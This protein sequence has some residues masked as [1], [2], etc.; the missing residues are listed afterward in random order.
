M[1]FVGSPDNLTKQ[2]LL[3]ILEK[4]LVNEQARLGLLLV[5]RL[6]RCPD[7]ARCCHHKRYRKHY[8][9]FARLCRPGN[10][11][12]SV[13]KDQKAELFVRGIAEFNERQFFACHETLETLWRALPKGDERDMIQSIIQIAVGFYH[14]ERA[15]RKGARKLLV[16]ATG[17]LA[18]IGR[19][20]SGP[21][22]ERLNLDQLLGHVSQVLEVLNREPDE[23][24]PAKRQ[25]RDGTEADLTRLLDTIP[26][27]LPAGASELLNG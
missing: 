2:Q 19:V 13:D 7:G 27:I 8:H 6:S 3:S 25:A 20:P 24:C 17:R 1:F 18:A 15:N 22:E 23:H 14:L 10:G 11:E 4:H 12:K 9:R 21:G 16:R 5:K 26:P